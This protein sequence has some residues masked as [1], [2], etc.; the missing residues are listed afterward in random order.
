MDWVEH[1]V[2]W[3]FFGCLLVIAEHCRFLTHLEL[4]HRDMKWSHE[5]LVCLAKACPLEMLIVKGLD[6]STVNQMKRNRPFMIF[7]ED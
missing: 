7:S 4:Y 3:Q 6:T 5:C 2:A 1:L